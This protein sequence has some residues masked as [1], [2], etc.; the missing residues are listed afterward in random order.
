MDGGSRKPEAINDA[1]VVERVAVY[2]IGRLDKRRE[3]ADVELEATRKQHGVLRSGEL[4][5]AE[6]DRSMLREI[7]TNQA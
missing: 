6:F 4:C 5:E 2:P 3:D 1:G 7:S